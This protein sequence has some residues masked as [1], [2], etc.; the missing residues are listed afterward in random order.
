MMNTL[1]EEDLQQLVS[2][3]ESKRGCRDYD[4]YGLRQNTCAADAADLLTPQRISIAGDALVDIYYSRTQ[5]DY[6]PPLYSFGIHFCK[7]TL[8]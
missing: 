6:R 5:K 4:E 3:D 7:V 2:G 1:D 8:K